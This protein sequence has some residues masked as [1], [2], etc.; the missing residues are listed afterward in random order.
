VGLVEG[1]FVGFVV[2]I[3]HISTISFGDW[4]GS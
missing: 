2:G 4:V 3:V 1:D